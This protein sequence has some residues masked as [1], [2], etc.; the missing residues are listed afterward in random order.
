MSVVGELSEP[1]EQLALSLVH[2]VLDQS[3]NNL[4][5]Q[6]I[7]EL[8][9]KNKQQMLVIG[10]ED[11]INAEANRVALSDDECIVELRTRG[12]KDVDGSMHKHEG[13]YDLV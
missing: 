3:S 11:C 2:I 9:L 12:T 5:R 8:R 1:G 10:D 4:L 6:S 13:P 7:Y